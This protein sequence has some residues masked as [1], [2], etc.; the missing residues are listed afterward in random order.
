MKNLFYSFIALMAGLLALTSLP[1]AAQDTVTTK[2]D[3]YTLPTCPAPLATLAV[4]KIACKAAACGNPSNGGNTSAGLVGFLLQAAGQP[5]VTGIGNGLGDM[6][7]TAL[8]QTNCFKVE[9]MSALAQI[10]KMMA[11]AGAAAVK[12]KPPRYMVLGAITDID[13]SQHG[14]SFGGGLIPII[15]SITHKTVVANLKLDM[16]IVDT[17]Q[18]TILDS[19]TFSA[20]SKQGSFGMQ[21]GVISTGLGFGGSYSSLNNTPLGNVARQDIVRAVGYLVDTIK[22]DQAEAAGG[23]AAT[24]LPVSTTETPTSS[25]STVDQ[26]DAAPAQGTQTTASTPASASG[27][28]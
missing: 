9:S 27:S 21:G 28:D 4:G 24:A 25:S 15:G 23:T 8:K 10:N 14:G 13:V 26:A 16:Q 7:V 20:T 5:S 11:E 19:K 12:I 18:A 3:A 6:L 1:A 17:K 22:Q 2:T